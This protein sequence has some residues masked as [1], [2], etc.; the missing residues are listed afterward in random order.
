MEREYIDLENVRTNELA[1]L[2]SIKSTYETDSGGDN[3]VGDVQ[4]RVLRGLQVEIDNLEQLNHAKTV[5]V[6][7]DHK[8][9]QQITKLCG[10]EI[11]TKSSVDKEE[12]LKEPTPE[13]A[14]NEEYK[15]CSYKK[16]VYSKV[17]SYA[18]GSDFDQLSNPAG[19]AICQDNSFYVADH[20]NNRVSAYTE[21]GKTEVQL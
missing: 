13:T 4:G 9:E 5:S 20:N 14:P 12:K 19:V 18:I 7:W 6:K 8:L 15:T 1:K 2:K 11:N 3:R 21:W 17:E 10:I 16:I